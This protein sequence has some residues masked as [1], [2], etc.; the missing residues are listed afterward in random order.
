VKTASR[1]LKP[2]PTTFSATHQPGRTLCA[3][4]FPAEA[5]RVHRREL[6]T[7]ESVICTLGLSVESRDP[8]TE[9][10]CVNGSQRN[11]SEMGRHLN[12]DEI[13]LWRCV[14]EAF[15]TTSAR[16]PCRTK[17]S[18]KA[19]NLTPAEWEIMKKHPAGG[20]NNLPSLKSLR[21]VAADHPQPSRTLR[22]QRLSRRLSR[23]EIR[24]CPESCR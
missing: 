5:E 3:R 14:V 23:D 18:I 22:R 19:A 1:E 20:R 21:L 16:L 2:E 12:L 24:S 10:H 9:G 6:E 4:Q 15:C 11:A 17:S 7:A 13:V 8:Y